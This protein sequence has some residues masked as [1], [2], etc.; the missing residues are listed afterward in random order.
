MESEL[1][2]W[3]TVTASAAD[4]KITVYNPEGKIVSEKTVEAYAANTISIAMHADITV[5]AVNPTMP[6]LHTVTYLNEKGEQLHTQK[7]IEGKAAN[8]EYAP[9]DVDLGNGYTRTYTGKWI[10]ANGESVDLSCV[11]G[12][13]TVKPESLVWNNLLTYDHNAGYKTIMGVNKYVLPDENGI[14]TF[15][16]RIHGTAGSSFAVWEAATWFDGI[17]GLSQWVDP[18]NFNKWFTIVF[19]SNTGVLKIFDF[20]GGIDA[21]HITTLN[22]KDA[23]GISLVISGFESADI[24]AVNPADRVP[25]GNNVGEV[26]TGASLDETVETPEL[27]EKVMKRTSFNADTFTATDISVYSEVRFKTLYTKNWYLFDGGWG[28]GDIS[29]NEW[30]EWQFVKTGD[31]WMLKIYS[32]AKVYKNETGLTGTTIGAIVKGKWANFMGGSI[33]EADDFVWTTELRAK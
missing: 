27:Y 9:E 30:I 21:G 33:G 32:A 23:M 25:F 13:I 22:K 20:N 10:A 4:K 5:A 31:T 1:N 15:K 7:V 18:V 14:L 29:C 19:D 24:A 26:F 3:F 11:N 8:Y 2:K 28:S 12:D 16:V 6:T 17:L